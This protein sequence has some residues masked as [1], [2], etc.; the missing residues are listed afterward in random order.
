MPKDNRSGFDNSNKSRNEMDQLQQTYS[1][2]VGKIG[3]PLI[4]SNSVAVVNKDDMYALSQLSQ[5]DNNQL[6]QVEYTDN[7]SRSPLSKP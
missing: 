2:Q 5:A 7:D 1:M 3:K 6:G 4:E